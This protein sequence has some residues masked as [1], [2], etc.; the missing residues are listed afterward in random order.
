MSPCIG[1]I[2]LHLQ[3]EIYFF[4][5]AHATPPSSVTTDARSKKASDTKY[6][7]EEARTTMESV[8]V[9]FGDSADEQVTFFHASNQRSKHLSHHSY[10][11]LAM[12]LFGLFLSCEAKV[13]LF[14]SCKVAPLS[15]TQV[16]CHKLP[17]ESRHLAVHRSI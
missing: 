8:D 2:L 16:S 5:E 7:L 1:R 11:P 10:S 17:A 14:L 6:T 12:L 15:L 4:C 13:M 3:P 9:M